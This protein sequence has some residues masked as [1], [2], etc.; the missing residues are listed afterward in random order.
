M[1]L[2]SYMEPGSILPSLGLAE[3][4]IISGVGL[5]L[6]ASAVIAVALVIVVS[7]RRGRSE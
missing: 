5:C 2:P 3:V 6:A 4:G 7:H 1:K